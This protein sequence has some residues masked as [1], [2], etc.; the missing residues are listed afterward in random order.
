M[1]NREI[2]AVITWVDGDDPD[3]RAERSRAMKDAGLNTNTASNGVYETRFANNGE[4]YICVA[5]IL[6]HAPFI[7][8]IYVVTAAQR[9]DHWAEMVAIAAEMNVV[10]SLVDHKVIFQK[11]EYALPTFNS[12]SIETMLWRIPGIA[13]YYLYFNDDFFLNSNLSQDYFFT[14]DGKIRIRGEVRSIWPLRIK[15]H[16]RNFRYRLRGR[17]DVPAHFGT[18]L[19]KGAQHGGSHTYINFGHVPQLI[20]PETLCRWLMNRPQLLCAQITHRFRS[21]SQ[22]STSALANSLEIEAKFAVVE[23]SPQTIY[24][25]PN[26]SRLLVTDFLPAVANNLSIFGCIQSL[27]EFSTSDQSLIMDT[28][29]RKYE[30]LLPAAIRSSAPST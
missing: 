18:S 6:A 7:R 8:N 30:T 22:F 26:L 25:K 20:R 15:H 5:S 9:P 11:H 10:L 14:T 28:F 29:S 17:T 13:Q 12:I 19:A 23:K 3:H 27:D 4:I 24:M 16:L 21:I 2:D 1:T